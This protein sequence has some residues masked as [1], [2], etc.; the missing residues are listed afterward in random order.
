MEQHYL[1]SWINYLTF[2]MN[3]QEKLNFESSI[4]HETQAKKELIELQNLLQD[5]HDALIFLK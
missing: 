1:N 5:L 4:L 3:Q 2:Q